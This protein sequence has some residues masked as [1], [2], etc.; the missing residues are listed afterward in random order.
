MLTGSCKFGENCRDYHP[1]LS[2]HA[3]CAPAKVPRQKSW[4]SESGDSA[5]SN[6]SCGSGSD[7]DF[8]PS[9]TL[10]K[11]TPNPAVTINVR[12]LSLEQVVKKVNGI[13]NKLTPEKFDSLLQQLF[14]I[15]AADNSEAYMERVVPLIFAKAIAELKLSSLYATL[16]R[17]LYGLVGSEERPAVLR[18]LLQLSDRLIFEIAD[19][20]SDLS[21]DQAQKL[22]AKRSG[23]IKFLAELHSEGVIPAEEVLR[24]LNYLLECAYGDDSE[25]VFCTQL[26]CELLTLVGDTLP[27]TAVSPIMQT[28]PAVAARH[29]PRVQFLVWNLLELR[30]MKPS[31]TAASK[32]AIKIEVSPVIAFP[33][34]T[35]EQS[36]FPRSPST[37]SETPEHSPFL[38]P[39]ETSS[40]S[41]CYDPYSLNLY[42]TPYPR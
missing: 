33:R 42:R 29:P 39:S 12:E 15:V 10:D 26:V 21:E 18:Q 2:E 41:F 22:Q 9:S 23:N 28:L 32:P 1:I 25:A 31:P 24:R 38:S 13:L 11:L 34:V 14:A 40:F 3:P 8:T 35:V 19:I 7:N 4:A 36:S 27:W 30:G 6:S 16:T 37:S 17:H 5:C 20:V